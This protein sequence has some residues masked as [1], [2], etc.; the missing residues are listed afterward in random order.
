MN[1]SVALVGLLLCNAPEN[2]Q[3]DFWIGDW[4]VSDF[5]RS[6]KLVARVR[7]SPILDGC[8]LQEDYEDTAGLRGRSISIYDASRKV[9]QQ[10]WVTN[11][12]VSDACARMCPRMMNRSFRHVIG[13]PAS[14]MDGRS[15]A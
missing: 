5:D 9:W 14:S 13:V 11:R 3:F 4:D 6:D 12:A 7:V 1:A 2:R 15:S 8:A 10:N